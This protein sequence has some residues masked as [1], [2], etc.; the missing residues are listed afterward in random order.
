MLP[1][2]VIPLP[3][4][5]HGHYHHACVPWCLV[6][7]LPHTRV[8]VMMAGGCCAEGVH[9]CCA[10][11]CYASCSQAALKRAPSWTHTPIKHLN[12]A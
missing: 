12:V 8:R 3:L 10:D 5:H 6:M 1:C 2:I 9:G 7:T 11:L 4:A